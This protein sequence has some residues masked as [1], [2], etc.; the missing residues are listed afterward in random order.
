ME[1]D[2]V[3]LWTIQ[4]N[5]TLEKV[6]SSTHAGSKSL[7]MVVNNSLIGNIYQPIITSNNRRY[8]LQFCIDSTGGPV[9]HSKVESEQ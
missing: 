7:R 3:L 4:N 1:A 5:A 2:N 6:V 8:R 9:Q